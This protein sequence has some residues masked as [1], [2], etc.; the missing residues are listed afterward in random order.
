MNPTGVPLTRL[1]GSTT[2][3]NYFN[4]WQ[5]VYYNCSEA[6]F[7][8]DCKESIG[9]IVGISEH[10][11]HAQYKIL[12]SDTEYLIYRSLLRP[13]TPTDANLRAVMFEGEQDTHIV[14][15]IIKS[16][17]DLDIMDE[18]KTT[19]TAA[20]A[21]PPPVINTGD[22]IGRSFLMDKQEDGQ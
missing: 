1:T 6:S 11:G 10:C 12:N 2:D 15:P 20:S 21:S 18:S 4:F 19:E 13:P 14:D 8:S 5:L 16:R 22:L 7:P 3:I 9:H 17:H